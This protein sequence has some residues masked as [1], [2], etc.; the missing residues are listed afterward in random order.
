MGQTTSA[1]EVSNDPLE[2]GEG[3]KYAKDY[4][5]R[6][7]NMSQ[8]E[9]IEQSLLIEAHARAS[10]NTRCCDLPGFGCQKTGIVSANTGAPLGTHLTALVDIDENNSVECAEVLRAVCFVERPAVQSLG[11][12]RTQES[13]T[14]LNVQSKRTEEQVLADSLSGKCLDVPMEFDQVNY[15]WAEPSTQRAPTAEQHDILKKCV[16]PFIQTMLTGVSVRL[17]LDSE[18]NSKSSGDCLDA[19]VALNEDLELLIISANGSERSFPV[20]AIRSVRPPE[21]IQKDECCVEFQIDGGRFMRFQFERKDHAKFFGT[22][23]QLIVK[24]S[25]GSGGATTAATAVRS[26]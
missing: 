17:R 15:N 26:A 11:G 18:A 6:F 1:A 12:V 23:M 16:K 14:Y 8:S 19:S 3:R 7:K 2:I 4:L 13:A 22:C 25:K 24:A 10:G 21:K 20:R 5:S 9:E